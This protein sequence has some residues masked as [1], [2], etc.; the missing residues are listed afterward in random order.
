MA[1]DQGWWGQLAE[2]YQP[3]ARISTSWF[4]GL[5]SEYIERAKSM[6]TDIPSLHHVGQPVIR[7]NGD[8]AVADVPMTAEFRGEL[9]GAEVDVIACIRFLHRAE[10]RGGPW[11]LAVT[12]AIFERDSMIPAVPGTAPVLEAGALDKFRPSYRMLSLW[13]TEHGY[14]VRGDRLGLDR[15]T[16]VTGLYESAYRWA[17]LPFG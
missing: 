11:R 14:E 3:D 4:S 7:A 13:L 12:D 9:R 1:R 8:R 2:C 6:I 17:G 5:A 10:R 15:P 16:E